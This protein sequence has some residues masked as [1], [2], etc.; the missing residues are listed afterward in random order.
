MSVSQVVKML[1]VTSISSNSQRR[2]EK[3]QQASIYW[4]HFTQTQSSLEV[5]HAAATAFW[6]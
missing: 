4:Q 3:M 1:H 5:S 6:L 2:G